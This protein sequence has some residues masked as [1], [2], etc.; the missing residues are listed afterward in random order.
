[1]GIKKSYLII[2]LFVV[3]IIFLAFF[4]R[5]YIKTQQSDLKEAF[6]AK[7]QNENSLNEIDEIEKVEENK[8]EEP[9]TLEEQL[10]KRRIDA[11]MALS[12]CP[13]ITKPEYPASYYQGPLT[14]THLHLPALADWPPEED[15]KPINQAPEGRFG[16][17]EAILGWNIKIS[18]I[19]CTIQ[20]EGTRKNFAFFPIY[21]DMPEQLLEVV[22]KT[23]SLY[24]NQF[25]PFIMSSGNDDEP[26]GF[27]TVDSKTLEGMLSPYPSL[28]KGYGEIGLYEREKGSPELP[29]DS[30]RLLEIYPI[31]RENKLAVYFHLE[32]GHKDNFEKVLKANPDI[33]FIWHGDQLSKDEIE[34]ILSNNPNAY[35]G[36]DAFWGND[37]DLFLLFVGGKTKKPY[38]N[39]LNAEFDKILSYAVSDWKSIIE[40]HP[41]QFLWGIDRGDAVWNYDIEVGQAQVKLA[42]AFIGKLKPDVQEKIAYKNAEKLLSA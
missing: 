27:P 24:P 22:N 10:W 42:R 14:D 20:Q 39:E 26:D 28:F 12:P 5:R 7:E 18:E 32:E 21:E 19:A 2:V 15:S 6:E 37:Q 8:K 31:I 9:L 30:R 29:P 16:G 40:R 11:A 41:D 13:N 23:M 1:M 36:V 38:L 25:T 34:N 33:N 17:P 3:L 35:F 4:V